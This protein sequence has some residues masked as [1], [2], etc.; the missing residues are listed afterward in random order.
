MCTYGCDDTFGIYKTVPRELIPIDDNLTMVQAGV[1]GVLAV[2]ENNECPDV[3]ASLAAEEVG[4]NG[5]VTQLRYVLC[6][7][8][9]PTNRTA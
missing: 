3:L 7:A 5:I 6:L 8:T 1:E 9:R 2:E 4:S